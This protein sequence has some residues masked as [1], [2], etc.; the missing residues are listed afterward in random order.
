MKEAAVILFK[1]PTKEK[2]FGVTVEKM[3]NGDWQRVWAFPLDEKV[4]KNEG[5]DRIQVQGSLQGTEK[6]PGCPFC[7]EH[8]FFQCGNCQ[9]YACYHGESSVTCP[10]CNAKSKVHAAE[11]FKIKGSAF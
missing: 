4:A 9:R 7:K 10:W 5:F 6:Y 3:Q 11:M 1:C 2:T 8:S